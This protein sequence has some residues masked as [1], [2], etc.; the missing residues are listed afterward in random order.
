MVL[1]GML[2]AGSLI[3]FIIYLGKMYKPMQELSKMT[4][5]WSK[6]EVG[7]ERI[8]EVLDT[9]REVKDLPG[10]RNA[11]PFKGKIEFEHV[12]YSYE[13]D[14]PILKDVSFKIEPGQV[15]ALVGPTGAG[16]TTII[17]LIPRFYDP[18]SGVVKI[19]DQ[20]IR[21]F[22]LKSLRQQISFVLQETLLFHA[23]IWHNI[24]YGKPEATRAEILHAAELANAHEFIEKM[25]EGYNTMVGERGV[26]L[27][28]GQRQRIAIAR[29]II[30]NTPILIMDEPSSGLD[31]ASEKLVF[32]ALD[33]LME[34]KTSIVIAHRLSTI[35]NADIIFVL[36][37]GQI[38][39]SGKH[40]E[41][42]KS[43]G[44]YSELHELQFAEEESP[45]G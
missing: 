21:R 28:G 8:R 34:G 38:V 5:A 35:R 2:T 29:A 41:L 19:D 1:G 32:E 39:E 26:T 18:S 3:V 33:R 22:K 40:E 16:K 13:P 31:A 11:A 27:S 7:Y 17:S 23:P 30:R 20:D 24:A 45:V 4:D 37:D 44:L 9:V 42:S 15:A 10:A 6:A 12:S 43:G 36:K 14:R 25:P